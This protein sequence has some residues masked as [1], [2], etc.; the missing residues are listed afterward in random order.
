MARLLLCSCRQV[1]FRGPKGPAGD[2]A[3]TGKAMLGHPP[4]RDTQMP[5]RW[6]CFRGGGG[7][8]RRRR[9]KPGAALRVSCSRLFSCRLACRQAL[10]DFFKGLLPTDLGCRASAHAASCR[11]TQQELPVRPQKGHSASASFPA[12][13][14]P[15]NFPL[16]H[17]LPHH[18]SAGRTPHAHGARFFPAVFRLDQPLSL[19]SRTALIPFIPCMRSTP[20]VEVGE[21]PRSAL[22]RALS[23]PGAGFFT[24]RQWYL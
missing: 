11:G 3:S 2:A 6:P 13:V 19:L 5:A 4:R 22:C 16:P 20:L 21:L 24:W 23:P 8:V 1:A 12:E 17:E 7:P 15:R 10:S 14:L 9:K 18:A